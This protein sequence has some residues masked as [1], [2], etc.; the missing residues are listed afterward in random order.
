MTTNGDLVHSN[1][2]KKL[3]LFFTHMLRRKSASSECGI[4]A[5]IKRNNHAFL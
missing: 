5:L 4:S 1:F 3:K 2:L